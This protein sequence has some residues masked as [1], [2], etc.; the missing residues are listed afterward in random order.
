MWCICVCGSMGV[1]YACVVACGSVY[2]GGG[3]CVCVWCVSVCGSIY[4]W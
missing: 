1:V 3:M 2:V 4:A